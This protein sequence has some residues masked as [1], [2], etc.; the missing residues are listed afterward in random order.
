MALLQRGLGSL[1]DF[2][3]KSYERELSPGIH[4]EVLE[5]RSGGIHSEGHQAGR[6]HHRKKLLFYQPSVVHYEDLRKSC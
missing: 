3:E 5:K 2:T 4:A 6:I 1:N